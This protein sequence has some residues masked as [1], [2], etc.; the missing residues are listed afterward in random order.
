M[1]TRQA[2]GLARTSRGFDHAVRRLRGRDARGGLAAAEDGGTIS[3]DDRRLVELLAGGFLGSPGGD[4][5]ETPPP[6][7]PPA[8]PPAELPTIRVE[9]L[10]AMI[11]E[12]HSLEMLRHDARFGAAAG[13]GRSIRGDGG[14]RGFAPPGLR[15][16]GRSL[17]RHSPDACRG[18][19]GPGDQPRVVGRGGVA[20]PGGDEPAA[21]IRPGADAATVHRARD[22]AGRPRAAVLHPG[23]PRRRHPGSAGGGGGDGRGGALR[24]AGADGRGARALLVARSHGQAAPGDGPDR[25]GRGESLAGRGDPRMVPRLDPGDARRGGGRAQAGPGDVRGGRPAACRPARRPDRPRAIAAGLG[26]DDRL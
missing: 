12:A 7:G 11:E 8:S 18:E 23:P 14:G 21:G 2:R 19:P 25:V 20:I 24:R 5:E 17:R 22:P 6:D 16:G 13:D 15:G 1:A 9:L 3:P 4:G 26:I 10:H